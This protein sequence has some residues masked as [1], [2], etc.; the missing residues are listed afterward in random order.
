M[1]QP[2]IF[3]GCIGFV[4]KYFGKVGKT[5]RRAPTVIAWQRGQAG[6]RRSLPPE[7]FPGDGYQPFPVQGEVHQCK[8]P[9]YHA[10]CVVDL[11]DLD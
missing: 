8:D 6:V 9:E 4:Q 10:A 5:E 11:G 1:N 2:R 7:Q 3:L